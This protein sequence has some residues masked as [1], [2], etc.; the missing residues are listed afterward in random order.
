MNDIDF[1]QV[2][3]EKKALV[4][5]EIERYLNE[6]SEFSDYC[7]I[8]DK[9][10][11]LV[12]FHQ[13][14]VAEYPKRKG[15][16]LRPS[17]VLLTASAMGFSEEQAIKTAA[18]MQVSED[19]ILN[20]DDIEDD[21]LQ[22]RGLPALHKEYG[23][24]LAINAGDALHNLMWKI[25]KDNFEMIGPKKGLEILEEFYQILN[26]TTLGQT[27]EIKWTKENRFDLTDD[28]ILFISESK[29]GYYTIA[30][31]MRL[32]AI[33]AGATNDQ[34]EKLY[35]FGLIL[36][37]C[38]QI[39]DDLLDLISDFNGLKKQKGND[40]YEGKRTIMLMHLLRRI[41]VGDKVKA[42]KILS[43]KREEKKQ[44]EIDWILNKMEE[45]GSLEYGKSL[46]ERFA[47]ESLEF[48]EK[49]LDFL[50][51]QPARD[52][53]KAGIEFIVKRDH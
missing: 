35:E 22:R 18:A 19:W 29:T 52:Q 49:K 25:L 28:D 47:K 16:Y 12:N 48:F 7:K 31:P 26:R 45:Y 51:G 5:P 2:L 3:E 36:G 43:K 13:K 44:E 17:L 21:S 30:G 1:K 11:S 50:K 40:I 20:H 14:L 42:L 46:A 23:K 6:L 15:K 37:R 4:W 32:G 39:K 38:F 8:Q 9:Y 24:E 27:V 41:G 33:L 34:I 10:T 53:L